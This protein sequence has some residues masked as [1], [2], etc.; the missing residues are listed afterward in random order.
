MSSST[1]LQDVSQ[2]MRYTTQ[3]GLPDFEVLRHSIFDITMHAFMRDVLTL[4]RMRSVIQTVCM[5]VADDTTTPTSLAPSTRESAQ[6]GAYQGVCSA[7]GQGLTAAS[8]A[9]GQFSELHGLHVPMEVGAALN[10]EA[11]ALK[12]QIDHVTQ[13]AD[14]LSNGNVIRLQARGFSLLLPRRRELAKQAQETTVSWAERFLQECAYQPAA[15]GSNIQ[16]SHL[17]LGLLTTGVLTGLWAS[18]AAA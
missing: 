16:A 10:H 12:Q 9:F 13:C 3:A 5:G 14:W 11:L 1:T 4:E 7:A 2:T 15:V 6:R 18:Q 8:L 17:L